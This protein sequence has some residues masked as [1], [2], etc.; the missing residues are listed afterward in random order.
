MKIVRIVR[1]KCDELLLI[2]VFHFVA[3]N[4]PFIAVTHFMVLHFM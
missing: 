2:I 1:L 3:Y 4:A